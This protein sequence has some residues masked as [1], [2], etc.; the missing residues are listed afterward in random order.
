MNIKRA[1]G[2]RLYTTRGEKILDLSM[3]GGR[4][5]LG[6]RPNG[7]S[8]TLKN[9]IDRG[10]YVDNG[11]EF[12]NRLKKDLSKRFPNHPHMILLDHRVF[13]ENYLTESI[14][15]PLFGD[16][17]SGRVSVWRPFLEIPDSEIIEVLYPLP[18]INTT[19]VLV[20]KR[21][22]D[23][24]SHNISPV[25]LSGILRSLYDYDM[26]KKSFRTEIYSDFS[27]IKQVE[28]NAPYMILKCSDEDYLKLQSS[29]KDMG[30]LLNPKEKLVI[31]PPDYSKGEMVKVLKLFKEIL[32]G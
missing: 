29:A 22:L 2:H 32:N 6:H 31:L 3:D 17:S 1:R 11:T 5:V 16:T 20:S 19:C 18:G 24:I 10:I 13:L 21:P 30:I 25:I 27:S 12:K 14:S 4:A 7:L 15:D 8:L 28:I 26:V 9:S 23:L